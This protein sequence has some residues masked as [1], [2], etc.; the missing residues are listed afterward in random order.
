MI[1]SSW[2]PARAVLSLYGKKPEYA[3]LSMAELATGRQVA[4]FG[5]L[6]PHNTIVL[7]WNVQTDAR[8]R[9]QPVG[10]WR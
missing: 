3:K 4:G 6:H 5:V 9:A 2:V 10:I 7:L 8:Q 1:N